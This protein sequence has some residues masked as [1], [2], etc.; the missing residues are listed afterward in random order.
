MGK[1]RFP[2]GSELFRLYRYGPI[3]DCCWQRE[4]YSSW[5]PFCFEYILVAETLINYVKKSTW[6]HYE[7]SDKNGQKNRISQLNISFSY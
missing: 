2:S 1:L 7:S 3:A 5:F 4:S 6:N